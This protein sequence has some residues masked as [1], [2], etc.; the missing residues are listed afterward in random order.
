MSLK[1]P[2]SKLAPRIHIQHFGRTREGEEVQAFRLENPSGMQVGITNLGG[3]LTHLWVPDRNGQLADVVLGFDQLEAYL[4]N[5]PYLGAV[6]G[7]FANRIGNGAFTLDG[8]RY[9]LAKN[10]RP[11]GQP[12]H[13]HGGT[14]GWDKVVWRATA[15]IEDNVPTVK[16]Q[17]F[18]PD[19]DEG[20]PGA[21]DVTVIYRLLPDNSLEISYSAIS[22]APT[23]VNLTNHAYFNLCG[24]GHPSVAEHILTVHSDA[25]TPV[26]S[27][28]IPTGEL[29]KVDGTPFDFRQA[30]AIGEAIDAPHDQLM[31]TGGYDHNFVLKKQETD[32][33]VL[34]AEVYEPQSGR[35]METW[36]SEP[37][38]QFYAG[39]SLDGTLT[40]K[41]GKPYLRRSG[42]CLETQHYPDS[43]NQPQF[44]STIL[45]PEKPFQSRTVYRFK[46]R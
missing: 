16:L 42:F 20:Y 4:D 26:N 38:V 11:N 41:S 23:P 12:C 46:T 28:S 21:V 44:P 40:G 37:G 29:L 33:F 32:A 45:R 43:P 2:S 7:R 30:K 13:L 15:T 25:I 27:G 10:D 35:V 6:I 1:A 3:I 34:A 8:K 19:G 14:M 31:Y 24:E 39:N 9:E 22:D 17:H 36:T 5:G 18:S